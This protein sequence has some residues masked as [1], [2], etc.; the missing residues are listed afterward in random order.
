MTEGVMGEGFFHQDKTTTTIRIGR[1]RDCN[2]VNLKKDTWS[3]PASWY[4]FSNI[5][6]EYFWLE[7]WN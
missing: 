1:K 6:Q 3:I 2:L 7:S 5:R 4:I